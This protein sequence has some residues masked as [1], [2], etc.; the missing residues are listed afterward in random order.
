[1][2]NLLYRGVA[3]DKADKSAQTLADQ[4]K[5]PELTYRGVA[6]DGERAVDPSSA[7]EIAKFYRGQ[8]FA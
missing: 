4:M 1:M 6:H 2:T 8:R 3:Y 7:R 5:R